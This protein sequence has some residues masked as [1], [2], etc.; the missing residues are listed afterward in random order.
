MLAKQENEDIVD[1]DDKEDDIVEKDGE[2]PDA[3]D[4]EA[5]EEIEKEYESELKQGTDIFDGVSLDDPVRMYLKEIGQYNLLSLAQEKELAKRKAKGDKMA[6]QRL[7]ECNLRLVVS[8]A[9]KYVGHGLSL[10]DLI[11]EGNLGLIRGIEKFDY[12]MG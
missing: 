2:M 3:F 12:S 6:F 1:I 8:I 7:V 4:I 5:V 9:K 10:L 11:Q